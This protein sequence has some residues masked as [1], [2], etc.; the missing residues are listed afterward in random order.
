[1]WN[2]VKSTELGDS[3]LCKD[4][5][6]KM[7]I[8]E[9]LDQAIGK[10]GYELRPQIPQHCHRRRFERIVAD[11]VGMGF[12]EAEVVA[13]LRKRYV[14]E[15]VL[16]Y[17][18]GSY[19]IVSLDGEVIEK[20]RV[21]RREVEPEVV[22]VSEVGKPTE[23]QQFVLDRRAEGMMLDEIGAAYS[24]RFNLRQKLS[25]EKVRAILAQ[26]GKE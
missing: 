25:R 18:D 26:F 2:S 13:A 22:T 19:D 23:R 21:P 9:G 14:P 10:L 17:S 11:V 8:E 3:V 24:E 15:E 12:E 7:D 16:S 5:R 1:M 4:R 20:Y 6:D